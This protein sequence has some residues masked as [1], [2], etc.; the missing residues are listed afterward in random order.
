MPICY[1]IAIDMIYS[2]E[3]VDIRPTVRYERIEFPIPV[4]ND[5]LSER[6]EEF[7][8]QFV[9]IMNDTFPSTRRYRRE[10]DSFRV[11]SVYQC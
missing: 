11:I 3:G 2:E 9:A 4:S 1:D 7:W 8:N 10:D 6:V 5:V